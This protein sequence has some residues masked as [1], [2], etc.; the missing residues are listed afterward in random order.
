MGALKAALSARLAVGVQECLAAA[1]EI[2]AQV[3][4]H[5]ASDNG[6]SAMPTNHRVV[7]PAPVVLD[8]AQGGRPLRVTYPSPWRPV[9]VTSR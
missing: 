4:A 2:P 1:P 7:F 9:V 8:I 5:R 6:T 3:L